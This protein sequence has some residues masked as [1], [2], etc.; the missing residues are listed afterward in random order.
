MCGTK[1]KGVESMLFGQ[2]LGY[3][4]IPLFQ[5]MSPVSNEKTRPLPEGL[6]RLG[7]R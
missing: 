4:H 7:L 1:I 6:D 3:V 5:A 2:T